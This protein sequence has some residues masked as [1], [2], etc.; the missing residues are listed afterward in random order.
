MV[1][2][3][4]AL[5]LAVI[6]VVV[7]LVSAGVWA[8]TTGAASAKAANSYQSPMSPTLNSQ[9]AATVTPDGPKVHSAPAPPTIAAV[10]GPNSTTHSCSAGVIASSTRDLLITAAHCVSGDGTGMSVVPGYDAG[11]A[12]YGTWSVTAVFVDPDWDSKQSPS[13]DFAIL[14]VAPQQIS[15]M[16]E[17]VQDI[18]GALPLGTTPTNREAVTVQGFNAGSGDQSVVCTTEL[19]FRRGNPTFG[20][21]GYANGSSG[22]PW[23]VTGTD[24]IT[25]AIGVIGGL[26]QGGCKVQRS[27]S[28]V[29][30]ASVLNL[31]ARAERGGNDGDD[32]PNTPPAAACSQTSTS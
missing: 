17:H 4:L 19:A 13:D 24:H 16:P 18:T 29:F 27:F 10:F 32:A 30:G 6:A 15:G 21:D 3:R 14:R 31:L 2:I 26:H 23:M 25:R 5:A 22:S 28:P 7:V 8:M 11:R 12:P 20:C 9:K 1:R